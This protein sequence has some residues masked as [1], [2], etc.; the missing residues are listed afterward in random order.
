MED[1]PCAWI[2]ARC[3][4]H[5]ILDIPQNSKSEYLSMNSLTLYPVGAL[6]IV[7]LAWCPGSLPCMPLP[8]SPPAWGSNL[9]ASLLP[10]KLFQV[11]W[12]SFIPSGDGKVGIS[13]PC[14]FLLF[15]SLDL[16][17][18]KPE[19]PLTL[20]IFLTIYHRVQKRL[21]NSRQRRISWIEFLNVSL[22]WSQHFPF[23]S[24][25][26]WPTVLGFMSSL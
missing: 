15:S 22:M 14:L 6:I 10:T 16:P 24:G 25:S 8:L 18:N 21:R 26:N 9:L 5:M 3:L 23:H 2:C 13:I 7:F 11:C 12:V 1:M 4:T 20:G 19:G 17:R